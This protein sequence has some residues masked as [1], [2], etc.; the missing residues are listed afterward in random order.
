MRSRTAFRFAH[1][2][3][4]LAVTLALG[5]APSSAQDKADPCLAS[6]ST[7]DYGFTGSLTTTSQEF[8]GV[9]PRDALQRLYWT[10][11]QRGWTILSADKELGGLSATD[12]RGRDGFLNLSVEPLGAEGSKVS[13]SVLRIGLFVG[14]N[15]Q[16]LCNILATAA[17]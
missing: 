5:S 7:R 6:F 11:L 8:P 1:S 12:R 17:G 14:T 4:V 15:K 10:L 9:A 16:V 3:C 13:L 2:G